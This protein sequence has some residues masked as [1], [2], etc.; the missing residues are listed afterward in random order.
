M[1]ENYQWL[2]K[3]H[4][5]LKNPSQSLHY[6][7][8]YSAVKDSVYNETA[9]MQLAEIE[10]KYE[11]EKK[12]KEIELLNKDNEIKSLALKKETMFRNSVIAGGVLLVIIG[13]LLFNRFRIAQEHKQQVERLRISSDLHDE[14]GSTLSSIGMIS[15]YAATQ[16]SENKQAEAKKLL[17]EV[18]AS[19]MQMGDDMNDIIWAINPHNDTF[20]NIIN[21]LR[22]FASR[23]AESKRIQL[24]FDVDGGLLKENISMEKRKIFTLYV[25]K[26]LIMPLNI[27]VAKTSPFLLIKIKTCLS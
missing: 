8:L 23:T 20:E 25:K 17:T 2:S 13:L 1:Y 16:L 14:V 9:A 3:T 6:F 27:P 15:S 24:H 26:P 4:D 21:R 22:N 11:T 10:T 5:A 12:E 19:A 18:A 7:K